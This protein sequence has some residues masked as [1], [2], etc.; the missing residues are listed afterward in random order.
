MSAA[1]DTSHPDTS[2]TPKHQY[3]G[4]GRVRSV[5]ITAEEILGG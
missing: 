3:S 2:D 5:E 4:Q 1:E